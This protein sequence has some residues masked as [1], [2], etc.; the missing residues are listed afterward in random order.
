M[1]PVATALAKGINAK[2]SKVKWEQAKIK[3]RNHWLAAQGVKES[4]KFIVTRARTK[5]LI[6]K[7]NA[8]SVP[9]G[10]PVVHTKRALSRIAFNY[11]YKDLTGVAGPVKI[12]DRDPFVRN[13]V[14]APNA[15][16]YGGQYTI[17]EHWQQFG[18]S[19]EGRWV[20]TT[21]A[22]AGEAKKSRRRK[23]KITIQPR[24]FMK[25]ALEFELASG[26]V[27]DSFKDKWSM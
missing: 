22:S 10:R 26:N 11:S 9:G 8:V 5:E 20:R 2:V 19:K 23:R 3:R 25:P 13:A 6:R 18:R 12:P 4:L 1:N 17:Q 14:T 24:P 7:K 15:L 21:N 16:E 27:V